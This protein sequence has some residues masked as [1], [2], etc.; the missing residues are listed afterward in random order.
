MGGGNFTLSKKELETKVVEMKFDNSDFDQNVEKSIKTIDKLEDKLEFKDAGKNFKNIE[1]AASKV[2]ISSLGTAFETVGGKI[3]AMSVAG[4]TA[5]SNLTNKALDAAM[6]I[7]KSLSV[8][9]ISEGYNKYESKT[10]SVQ[11]L[12]NAGYELEEVNEVLDHLMWYSDE[13]SYSFS[14]MTQAL[15]T[16]ASQGLEIKEMIPVIEGMANA[17]SFAGKGAAEFSRVIFNLMQSFG[18]GSLQLRDWYSVNLAGVSS[19]RLKES[20]I[21]AAEAMGTIEKGA[22]TTGNFEDTLKDDWATTEVMMKAFSGWAEFTEEVYDNLDNYESTSDAMDALSGSTSDYAESAMRAAQT[23][24]S[25]T[26]AIEATKDAVSTGWMS[27]FDIIFGNINEASALWTDLTNALLDVFAAGGEVRNE[28]LQE[29]KDLG[30][31]DVLIDAFWG[32]WDIGILIANSLT[33]AFNEVFPLITAEQLFNITKKIFKYVDSFKNA[34]ESE[35]SILKDVTRG[36]SALLNI[37]KQSG[38]IIKDIFKV[39]APV[40]AMLGNTVRITL[41]YFISGMEKVAKTLDIFNRLRG[42]SLILKSIRDNLLVP[43]IN[44]L[45]SIRKFIN[46]CFIRP[47]INLFGFAEPSFSSMY[48]SIMTILKVIETVGTVI[49]PV[50]SVIQYAFDYITWWF[51]GFSAAARND[52][53]K[54]WSL[55]RANFVLLGDIIKELF[56]KIPEP[57]KEFADTV[58]E[59]LDSVK[60]NIIE[61]F[62]KPRDAMQGF[63]DGLNASSEASISLYKVF[64]RL[65]SRLTGVYYRLKDMTTAWGETS[66]AFANGAIKDFW[67][68]LWNDKIVSTFSKMQETFGKIGESFKQLWEKVK[69]YLEPVLN[70]I[71]GFFSEIGNQLKEGNFDTITKIIELIIG[72]SLVKAL[73]DF[74]DSF[75]DVTDAVAGVFNKL[76]AQIRVKTFKQ[77]SQ[78]ILMLAAACVILAFIPVDKLRT[79]ID[80]VTEIVGI[81]AGSLYLLAKPIETDADSV[82]NTA[83]ANTN[84]AKSLVVLSFSLI[85]IAS[86]MKNISEIEPDRLEATRDVVMIMMTMMVGVI[87]ILN[88]DSTVLEQGQKLG[89]KTA[90]TFMALASSLFIIGL[91]LKVISSIDDMEKAKQAVTLLSTLMIVI[92][93]SLKQL[94]GVDNAIKNATAFL[95]LSQSYMAIVSSLS[96]LAFVVSKLGISTLWESV[97]LIG[98]VMLIMVASLLALSKYSV[99][100]VIKG[101]TAAL[102]TA[103]SFLPIVTALSLLSVAIKVLGM[104]KLIQS[105]GLLGLTLI[106]M[107]GSL[108]AM[109]KYSVS[110][111]MKGAAAVLIMSTSFLPI[112]SSISLLAIAIKKI[113]FMELI[114]SIGA[115][116]LVIL[117]MTASLIAVSKFGGAKVAEGAT[118]MLLM[119]TAMIPIA[120]SLAVLATVPFK[121]LMGAVLA[122]ALAFSIVLGVALLASKTG[123]GAGLTAIA[124]GFL[125]F[126]A[127]TAVLSLAL[128]LFVSA[129]LGLITVIVGFAALDI[130]IIAGAVAAIIAVFYEFIKSLKPIGSAWLDFLAEMFVLAADKLVPSIAKFV[131]SLVNVIVDWFVK[132]I[133]LLTTSIVVMA[134]SVINALKALIPPIFSLLGVFFDNLVKYIREHGYSITESVV[135]FIVDLLKSLALHANEWG[136]YLQTIFW[137]CLMVMFETLSDL[138]T[139]IDENLGD[140][141]DHLWGIIDKLLDFLMDHAADF[142]VVGLSLILRL[143]EALAS[144]I[145]DMIQTGVDLILSLLNGINSA[146]ENNKDDFIKAVNDFI[147]NLIDVVVSAFEEWPELFKRIGKRIIEGDPKKPHSGLIGGIKSVFPDLGET[148]EKL[149]NKAKETIKGLP[150][151]FADAGKLIVESIRDGL[152]SKIDELGSAIT[153]L[154]NKIKSGWEDLW[155]INSPSKVM[156]K[157]SEYLID[158]AVKGIEKNSDKL[159]DSFEDLG[160]STLAKMNKILE[161]V[162]TSLDDNLEYT[163]TITPVVDLTNVQNGADEINGLMSKGYQTNVDTSKISSRTGYLASSIDA[164]K[165]GSL[166]FT[167]VGGSENVNN[168]TNNFT[169][170]GGGDPN[171]VADKV[172]KILQKQVD[173]RNATWA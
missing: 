7:A 149:W 35:D 75:G 103:T 28:I 160:D 171:V 157:D 4:I 140:W 93:V 167:P 32:V 23:S 115:L 107:V 68:D 84:A 77:I 79:A 104:A 136:R 110:N 54:V 21:E 42:A 1:D 109:S 48:K 47:L 44:V 170:N 80:G 150:E 52:F 166:N 125:V 49:K 38:I 111:I 133:P 152:T 2:D 94:K 158:G 22:I 29:W 24:K 156:E 114:E 69:P 96:A 129:L 72:G 88:K 106:V 36:A 43:I 108:L 83:K 92:V 3:S 78:S 63:T 143:I 51:L 127:A 120:T 55:I 99:D 76:E 162:N 65:Y 30:G 74:V 134:M 95:I 131:K 18:T 139:Y 101:A 142:T 124:S 66:N 40:V 82:A 26:D 62:T 145:P 86:A 87:K 85:L 126:A 33:D 100:N 159:E 25:F 41:S 144:K 53:F 165:I 59:N 34:L 39:V 5:I 81:L 146:I 121:A 117:T 89:D 27:T 128:N 168:I 60:Q 16:A 61:F 97:G 147:Y 148:M 46:T 91:T 137:N 50:L 9:Q 169:I 67:S 10:S 20:L 154:G 12:V 118:A 90:S 13:T 37:V 11:T 98:A 119:A 123:L 161:G 15:A 116:G 70:A 164:N 6:D 19:E 14:D 141:L 135:L 173:R 45:I 31:R 73:K 163:P 151:W 155:D 132:E 64:G 153:G 17:T 112:V 105:I 113:G 8:D 71:K 138:W 130:T 122:M 56:S 57:V 172:S 102:I 58:K